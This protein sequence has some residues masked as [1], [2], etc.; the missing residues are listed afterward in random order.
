MA[1]GHARLVV[2]VAFEPVKAGPLGFALEIDLRGAA[3]FAKR[4]REN[5]VAAGRQAG[6]IGPYEAVGLRF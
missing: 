2:E 4:A 5:R 3:G 1:R 6:G